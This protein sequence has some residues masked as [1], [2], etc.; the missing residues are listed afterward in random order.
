MEI[1]QAGPDRWTY[2]RL[3]LLADEEESMIE[4]YIHRGWM[5]LGIQ[6]GET[7]AQCIVTQEGERTVEIKSLSVA[8]EFQRRGFGRQMVEY[9]KREFEGRFDTMLVGTGDSPA[10]TVFYE[11]CGFV[12]SHIV[13]DFF[14]DNYSRPIID[15]GV[16]LRHMVY[17]KLDLRRAI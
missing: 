3:L 10:T 17:F 2:R 4:K 15:G 11:R 12:R 16:I 8:P 6:D 9:V 5:L 7:I 14:I 13:E 1:R